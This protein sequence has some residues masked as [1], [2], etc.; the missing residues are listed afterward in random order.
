VELTGDQEG[1]SAL[2][3]LHA[4]DK[5][6]LKFLIGE[7]RSNTDSI[8]FFTAA[9]GKKWQLFF[10]PRNGNIEVKPRA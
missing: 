8:A 5:S 4:Q 2:K 7:A 10:D 3:A 6:Y 1:I 9:D